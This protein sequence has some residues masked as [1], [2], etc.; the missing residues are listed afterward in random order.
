MSTGRSYSR[1][2]CPTT[3]HRWRSARSSEQHGFSE[4]KAGT[5]ANKRRDLKQSGTPS[6]ILLPAKRCGSTRSF[7]RGLT[8]VATQ[9]TRSQLT[10][11]WM[12]SASIGSQILQRRR[13]GYIGKTP[14]RDVQ[15]SRRG[16]SSYRWPHQSS[17]GRFFVL[18]RNG[19]RLSGQTCFTGTSL[20]R[21][22]TSPRS[23]SRSY[24]S[25][26]CAKH[27]NHGELDR[28]VISKV[29]ANSCTAPEAGA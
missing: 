13:L 19:L 17:R 28:P 8:I 12:I 21:V 1:Q 16:A 3:R 27:S 5:S 29:L 24:L 23:N 4:S 9:K 6:Q 20:T 18:Q 25:R 7:R 15:A 26:R 10:R 14:R 11:C 22:G 2:R